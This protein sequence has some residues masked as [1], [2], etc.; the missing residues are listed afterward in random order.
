EGDLL[1]DDG[2]S[3]GVD[4][5]PADGEFHVRIGPADFGFESGGNACEGQHSILPLRHGYRSRMPLLARDT[6]FERLLALDAGDDT[7]NL[8]LTLEDDVLLDMRFD[9]GEWLETKWPPL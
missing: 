7:D 2:G 5:D 9:I 1:R 6:D 8:V 3:I 4:F